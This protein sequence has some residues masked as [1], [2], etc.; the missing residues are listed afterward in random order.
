MSRNLARSKNF[1]FAHD[2]T[3][4]TN[5]KKHFFTIFVLLVCLLILLANASAQ[6]AAAAN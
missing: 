6:F 2:R 5:M 1:R 4:R 3:N